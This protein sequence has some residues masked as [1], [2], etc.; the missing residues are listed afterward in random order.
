MLFNSF[1]YLFLFLPIVA[2]CFHLLGRRWPSLAKSLLILASL[3]FYGSWKP[4]YLP[5]L[6]VSIL[7]NFAFGSLLAYLAPAGAGPSGRPPWWAARLATALGPR[8]LLVL[9]V[10]FNLGLLGFFKYFDFISINAAWV[11]GVDDPPLLEMLIPLGISFYT[12]QQIAYLADVRKG[13]CD[14]YRLLDYALF[15]SFFPQLVA[16]PIVHHREMMPQFKRPELFRADWGN[17]A[18]GLCLIVIGLFKK[19][20]VADTFAVWVNKGFAAGHPLSLLDSWGTSLSYTFQIYFDFSGYCDIA[21]GSALMFNI[22]LPLNFDSPYK[23]GDIQDFWRRWHMT[24]SRWLRDYI[25]IPLGGNRK[26]VPKSLLF[27][28]ITFLLGGIWHGANWTFALWGVL[29]ALALII[30][31]LWKLGGY[32][33]PRPLGWLVTFLFVNFAWVLFRAE[34]IT[35]AWHMFLAML[36]QSAAPAWSHAV[37]NLH[38]LAYLVI[39]A[40]VCLALPNSMQWASR[41]EGYLATRPRLAAATLGASALGCLSLIKLASMAP[42]EFIYFNF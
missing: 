25:Y 18:T 4:V 11:M 35:K 29:H 39:F 24:L 41:L 8:A 42:S 36:G 2:V 37:V 1:P 26:G 14:Q 12:F 17:R 33:L 27:V 28:F 22:I 20:F 34:S 38:T 40:F 13:I 10:A 21:L 5:I 31:R 9:G 7:V 32:R 15:V 30:S 3:V 23:A 6:L 16:G 19:V